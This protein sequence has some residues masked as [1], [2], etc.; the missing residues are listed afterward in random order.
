[1]LDEIAAERDVQHL[2]PATHG[3]DR[4]IPG[5]RGL[6]QRQLR[7][8][9]LGV[10]VLRLG[11]AV[12]A[13][14]IGIDVLPAREEQAVDDAEGLVDGVFERRREHGRPPARSTART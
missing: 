8:V 7:P 9:A 13:V 1:M 14:V 6:E 3:N 2:A 4:H 5:Q 11:M 12:G 10:G